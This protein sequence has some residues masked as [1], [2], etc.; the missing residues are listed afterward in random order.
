MPAN[1]FVLTHDLVQVEYN[2]GVTPGSPAL[3]YHRNGSKSFTAAQVATDSTALGSLVSVPLLVTVDTGGERFGF[4]LPQLDV[5]PGASEDFSTIGIYE[6]FGGPD[7]FPR[8]PSSWR[9]IEV[10]GTAQTVTHPLEQGK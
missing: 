10:R 8:R 4:Y 5:P 1:K 7:S 3:I 6:R 2:I 9:C